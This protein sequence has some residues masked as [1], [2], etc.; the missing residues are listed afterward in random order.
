MF[1]D[2]MHM[3][4]YIRHICQAT[5][6]YLRNIGA[7]QNLLLDCAVEQ[8]IHSLVTSLR[9][10]CNSLLY[11]VPGYKLKRLQRMSHIAA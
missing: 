1:D 10:Y 9:D 4:A 2:H 5:H 7:I 3:D 11:G 8:R 6:F